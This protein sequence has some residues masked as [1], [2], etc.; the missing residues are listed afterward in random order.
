M[1]IPKLITA[2]IYAR[3]STAEQSNDMQ[4]HDLRKYAARM[5]W[6]A[7]EYV[8][9]E[10]S[11]KKRPVFERMLRDAKEGRV[12]VILVWRI[13]RFARSMKDYVLITLE[14]YQQ[15][16]RLISVTENVDTGDENPFA[17]FQRGL[18]ALLAQLERKIIVARVNAGIAEAHRKGTHCG[19]P[20]KVWRRDDAVELRSLGL[21]FRQI[22]ARIGQSEASVRRALKSAT[23]G[24]PIPSP[25]DDTNT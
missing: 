24:L 3:V 9:K 12:N 6:P 14:L 2:A 7:V 4:L 5:E 22:G 25:A 11:V 18:L 23:K 8:E 1:P 21:S 10:S 17:E 19:R 15:K 13:D 20:V 16:V